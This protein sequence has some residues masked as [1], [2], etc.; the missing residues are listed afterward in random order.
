MGWGLFWEHGCTRVPSAGKIDQEKKEQKEIERHMKDL[1]N[2]LKKLNVLISK[3]RSSSEGLRQ[4]GLVT[5]QEFV[6]ALKVRASAGF[7]PRAPT[8]AG[9]KGAQGALAFLGVPHS[10]PRPCPYTGL[11]EGDHRDAGEAEPAPGG[12]GGHSEQPGGGGV[13][14]RPHPAPLSLRLRSPQAPTVVPSCQG[15]VPEPTLGA[16]V[17][18]GPTEEQGSPPVRPPALTSPVFG[19][20]E[21]LFFFF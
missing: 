18:G 17:G 8:C 5:E 16:G 21:G 20:I 10:R 3:N 19:E 12:E 15:A 2:D 4:D 9:R 1:D 14:A 11:R 6:R 13:S 7:G